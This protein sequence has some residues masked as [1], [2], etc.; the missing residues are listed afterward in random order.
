MISFVICEDEKLLIEEYKNII[1][2]YMMNYDYEYQYV[3]FD[4][5]DNKFDNYI[6]HQEDFKVYIL[7]IKTK[8]GY[9]IDA[10]RKIREEADDW[11]SIILIITGL[12]E[13]KNEAM[14]KRLMLMDFINKTDNY[15]TYLT[16]CISRC[17]KCYGSRP[18]KLKYT[19]KNTIY[20]VELKKIIYI[21]REQDSKRCII[22]TLDNKE[23][24]Y[25]GTISGL[26]EILDNRF[27]K[28]SR[29]TIINTRL[30]S[31]Y[32]QKTNE[33][34]FEN[35]IMVND[36]SRGNKRKVVNY[37]RGVE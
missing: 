3:I 31:H 25:I 29:C 24:P 34:Y 6:K 22:Y 7:D 28:T 1:D 23:I 32:N 18:N 19:Y 17:L 26:L 13:L 20:N 15:S 5:Y 2:K 14:S 4:G 8:T 10:A 21:Q 16:D 9:G 11:N 27:I 36:I 12:G 30:I 37:V 33:I 35:G